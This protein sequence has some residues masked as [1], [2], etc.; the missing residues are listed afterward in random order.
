MKKYPLKCNC[1]GKVIEY[2]EKKD[3]VMR[4]FWCRTNLIICYDL[5]SQLWIKGDK[6][7]KALRAIMDD[8]D[9]FSKNG[10]KN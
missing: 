1:C 2:S 5:L 8:L 7:N 3:L 10:A 6:K 9:K 4:C